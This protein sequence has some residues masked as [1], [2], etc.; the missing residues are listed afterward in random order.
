MVARAPIAAGVAALLLGG[1]VTSRVLTDDPDAVIWFDGRPVGKSGDVWSM[2]PPHTARV[3]VVA[4]D[5]RRARTL[6]EREFSWFTFAA[7]L[8]TLGVCFVFCWTYPQDVVVPLPPRRPAAGWD[9]DPGLDPWAEGPEASAW[10]APPSGAAT[11]NATVTP[12]PT[13]TLPPPPR[14]ATP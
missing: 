5:G 3:V 11:A 4:K 14:G 9:V 1:C 12:T 6:V 13:W 10:M 7:G 2:G 8:R